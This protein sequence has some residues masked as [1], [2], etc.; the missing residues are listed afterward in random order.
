ALPISILTVKAVPKGSVLSSVIIGKF[1]FF[2]SCSVIVVQTSPFP[3]VIIKLITS[4]ATFSDSATKSPSFSRFSSS[5]TIIGLPFFKSVIASS[6]EW[7]ISYTPAY[8]H[9]CV[10]ILHRFVHLLVLH[11][12]FVTC[13]VRISPTY[14][15]PY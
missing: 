13:D 7:H 6:I 12:S 8:N 11:L 4:G 2:D 5:T 3:C 10:Q 9:Y 15:T 1:N 14:H